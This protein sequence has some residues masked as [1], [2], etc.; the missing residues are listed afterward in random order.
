MSK[1]AAHS[2]MNAPLA[3]STSGAYLPLRMAQ[4]TTTRVAQ[5]IAMPNMIISLKK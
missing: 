3:N 5:P 1:T 2:N 4:P